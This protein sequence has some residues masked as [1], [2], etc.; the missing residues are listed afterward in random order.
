MAKSRKRGENYPNPNPEYH[1]LYFHH[2]SITFPSHLEM[3]EGVS[4]NQESFEIQDASEGD[5]LS[6]DI[7]IAMVKLRVST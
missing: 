2:I 7:W 3:L 5:L 1:T 4:E 6:H